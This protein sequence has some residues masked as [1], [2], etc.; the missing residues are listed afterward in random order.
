[1]W[2]LY[3]GNE[4]K[5]H[6]HLNGSHLLRESKFK[7]LS[8]VFSSLHD[9]APLPFSASFPPLFLLFPLNFTIQPHRTC[10]NSPPICISKSHSDHHWQPDHMLLPL[11]EALFS[12]WA[13]TH[14][15]LPFNDWPSHLYWTSGPVSEITS[16]GKAS[17]ISSIPSRTGALLWALVSLCISLSRQWWQF[18]GTH[19]ICRPQDWEGRDWLSVLLSPYLFIPSTCTVPGT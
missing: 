13:N 7:P 17:G 9:L 3:N 1:M 16:S 19:L 2:A 18:S 8:M 10:T 11:P 14:T 6:S 4:T 15:Y 5:S 12:I